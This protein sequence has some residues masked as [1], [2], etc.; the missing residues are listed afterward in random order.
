MCQSHVES[1]QKIDSI[2]FQQKSPTNLDRL[3]RYWTKQ[4]SI[5]LKTA[6]RL[7]IELNFLIIIEVSSPIHLPN[8]SSEEQGTNI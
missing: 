7:G 2:I 6:H 4:N 5:K 8:S 1:K 3:G